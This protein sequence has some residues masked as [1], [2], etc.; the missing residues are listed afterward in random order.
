MGVVN[1]GCV[2][3]PFRK[4]QAAIRIE[5]ARWAGTRGHAWAQ[6]LGRMV[7]SKLATLGGGG[8]PLGSRAVF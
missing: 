1:H 6:V 3:S 5:T 4:V 2:F 8:G 7:T